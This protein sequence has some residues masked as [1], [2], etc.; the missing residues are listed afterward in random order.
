MD[1]ELD[2][3][4]RLILFVVFFHAGSFFTQLFA[5][6]NDTVWGGNGPSLPDLPLRSMLRISLFF[7]SER[8]A[9]RVSIIWSLC[10][11]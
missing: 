3:G 5:I 2:F 8:E 6:G 4:G 7:E 1:S 11:P 9:R 10:S